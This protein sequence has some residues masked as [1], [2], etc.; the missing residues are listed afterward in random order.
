VKGRPMLG[1]ISGLFF[2]LFVA[3]DLQQFGVRPLDTFAVFG[4]PAVGL[5]LGLAL[6]WWAPFAR[7]KPK[8]GPEPIREPVPAGGTGPPPAS[9][10]ETPPPS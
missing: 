2:G 1:A 4:F 7:R 9:T 6:A 5:V 10:S 8:P 3:I